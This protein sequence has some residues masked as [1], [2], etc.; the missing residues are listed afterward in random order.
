MAGGGEGGGAGS[1]VVHVVMFPFL[2]FGHI[3]PFVQLARRLVSDEAAGVRVTFLTAAGIAPRVEAMLESAAGAVRVL[4]LNLPEVPGLPAGAASTADVSGDGAELLKLALDGTRPEV[5]ALLAELRPDAVLV[6]FATSWVC[7]VAA[8]LGAKV[9]YFSVFSAVSFAYFTVPAR[10][11][12]GQPPAA[13]TA[14]DL[15][16][17]PAGYPAASPL[18]SAPP[19][20]QG[21][22]LVYPYTSFH[23]MPCV[24]DRVVAGV[25]GSAGIVMK[26]CREMEGPYIDYISSQ[27]GKP[28]LLAGPVVPEPPQGELE[29]RW[30]SW[31]SS[32]P[33]DAVVFASFGSETFL[34]VAAATEL[35]LGLEATGRPFLAV[36]NFPKGP[37]AAAE[38]EARIPPGFEERVRGRGLVRTGWVPQQH[39]LRHRSVGC[40]VNHAGFSSVV[41]G[42]VAGCRLV[43]LPMKGDQYF[44]A[45]LFARELGV[46]VEV[47][48]RD[49]GWF[50]RGDVADAVAAAVAAGGDG[51]AKWRDFFTNEAVQNK[52]Q[53]DFIR[54]LKKVVRA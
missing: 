27:F 37:D 1:D 25:E 3:S 53:V 16:V 29:E 50:G 39:I 14:R 47:A 20:L 22:A 44:N 49:D 7:D 19:Q 35:L 52:F 17:A 31:L 12:G 26:T 36:L 46:G 15:M 42:L 6:E 51:D 4:P 38:L 23:G 24:Y 34:P 21:P 30:A 8:P 45:A 40:F 54:E 11:A 2:A 48:Q 43:L 28:V 5:R 33:D 9:L 13:L 41:E 32:F 10:L 18:T